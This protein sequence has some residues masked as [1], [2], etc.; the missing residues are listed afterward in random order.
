MN[1]IADDYNQRYSRSGYGSKASVNIGST[2]H[3]IGLALNF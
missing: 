2:A 1:E 3:G